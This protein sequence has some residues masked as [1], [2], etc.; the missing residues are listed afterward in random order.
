MWILI[1]GIILLVLIICC[2]S[3]G[4]Y[5]MRMGSRDQLF[6]TNQIFNG[7]MAAQLR[8]QANILDTSTAS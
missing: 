6:F 7:G 8:N 5:Q 1:G 4:I 2:M 3:C